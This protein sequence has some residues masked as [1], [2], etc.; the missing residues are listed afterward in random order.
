MSIEANRAASVVLLTVGAAPTVS[1][2]FSA[3]AEAFVD[4]VTGFESLFNAAAL[5]CTWTAA[6]LTAASCRVA[7]L[8]VLA[9]TG[10]ASFGSDCFTALLV[11][12]PAALVTGAA[13]FAAGFADLAATFAGAVFFAVLTF[14]ALTGCFNSG[15]TLAEIAFAPDFPALFAT[16]L[17]G[18]LITFLGAAALLAEPFAVTFDAVFGDG[19]AAT[20]ALVFVAG[21][22]VDLATGFVTDLPVDLAA[23]LLAL[24]EVVILEADP[25]FRLAAFFSVALEI[26]ALEATGDFAGF[27][28][29]L[30][31]ESLSKVN[32]KRA[33]GSLD[34]TIVATA[35]C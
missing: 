11:C 28:M 3:G 32:R 33:L 30:A 8:A 21:F 6:A 1:C 15:F 35:R 20:F 26:F 18:A 34:P 2:T 22:A 31:V 4:L 16:G 27:F 25:N 14:E 9:T 17:A 23:D 19:L 7:G 29:L 5:V 24:F 12:L 10:F 13:G